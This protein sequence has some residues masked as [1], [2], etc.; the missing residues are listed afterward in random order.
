M[1]YSATVIPLPLGFEYAGPSSM[2]MLGLKCCINNSENVQVEVPKPGIVGT[3]AE[4][5]LG[6]FRLLESEQTC[7]L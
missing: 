7:I 4:P 3:W 1:S 6:I 5:G 2:L